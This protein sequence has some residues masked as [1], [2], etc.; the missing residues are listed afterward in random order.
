MTV[1]DLIGKLQQ[2]LVENGNLTVL[3]PARDRAGEVI[4]P[5]ILTVEDDILYFL[6]YSD[7]VEA[8]W[9]EG[10]E[11]E[12]IVEVDETEIDEIIDP[13]GDPDGDE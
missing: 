6:P 9:N 7:D 3:T 10:S 1:S 13:E 4:S 8:E 11:E 2:I 12:E 5:P